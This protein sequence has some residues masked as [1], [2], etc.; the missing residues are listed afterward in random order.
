MDVSNIPTAIGLLT[1]LQQLVL[2]STT[3][4]I[5]G[6]TIPTE[7]GNCLAMKYLQI[8]GRHF[9]GSIPTELGRLTN[10][11]DLTL[12]GGMVTGSIPS[13][14]GQLTK[15]TELSFVGNRLEGTL[16]SELGKLQDLYSFQIYINDLTGSIPSDICNN[17]LVTIDRD[18]SIDK[19]KCC[20]IPCRKV[21]NA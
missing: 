2:G 11:L 9:S 19:C 16:P 1:N 4:G 20:Y 18:C 14:L 10:M 13:E 12:E 3:K 5:D 21:Q 17:T 7:L 6:G 15:L 8:N